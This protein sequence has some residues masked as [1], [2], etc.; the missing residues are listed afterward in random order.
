MYKLMVEI[1]KGNRVRQAEYVVKDKHLELMLTYC[2]K[3]GNKIT[4]I[5]KI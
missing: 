3:E 1:E 5:K 4:G 2:S